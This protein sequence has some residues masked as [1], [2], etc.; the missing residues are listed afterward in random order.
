MATSRSRE[1]VACP[2][3]ITGACFQVINATQKMETNCLVNPREDWRIGA[4]SRDENSW[5]VNWPRRSSWA[6]WVTVLHYRR[7]YSPGHF[8][9]NY[10]YHSGQYRD[11]LADYAVLRTHKARWLSNNEFSALRIS[12]IQNQLIGTFSIIEMI[13][14]NTAAGVF[15]SLST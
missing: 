13:Y 2:G 3:P 12:Q 9:V 1:M 5:L 15:C 6:I 10:L 11:R 8:I 7:I 14:F 4:P